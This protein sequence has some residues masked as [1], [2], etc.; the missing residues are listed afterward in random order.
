M[1]SKLHIQQQ[2]FE[3]YVCK[4][5]VCMYFDNQFQLTHYSYNITCYSHFNLIVNLI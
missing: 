1:Y 2:Y 4:L 3:V 5:S